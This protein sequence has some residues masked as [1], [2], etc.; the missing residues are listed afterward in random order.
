MAVFG[1]SVMNGPF[2]ALPKISRPYICVSL[3]FSYYQLSTLASIAYSL[4]GSCRVA[5]AQ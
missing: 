1:L 4:S 2:F 3:S 5:Q